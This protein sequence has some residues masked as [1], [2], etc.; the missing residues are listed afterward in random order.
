MKK[1][2]KA[3]HILLS[4]E[5][6]VLMLLIFMK[7]IGMCLEVLGIAL[8]IPLISVLLGKDSEFFG[9]DVFGFLGDVNQSNLTTLIVIFI[10]LA[11]LIKNLFLITNYIANKGIRTNIIT[12]NLDKKKIF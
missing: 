9:L 11:Y 6:K 5:K 7:I 1:I 2:Y 10:I 12:A 3:W 8:I 4:S